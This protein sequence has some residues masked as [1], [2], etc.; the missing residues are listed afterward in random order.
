MLSLLSS[1]VS[2]TN[3]EHNSWF[4]TNNVYYAHQL[5]SLN[6]QLYQKRNANFLSH[7][8]EVDLI[9]QKKMVQRFVHFLV[10]HF[11]M[12]R[13]WLNLY[14]ASNTIT[15]LIHI[16][17]N[18]NLWKYIYRTTGPVKPVSGIDDFFSIEH[19]T[20]VFVVH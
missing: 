5:Y 13:V 6:Q 4:S 20:V 3:T 9:K 14:G 15:A 18:L 11:F 8:P 19:Y 7:S 10:T 1:P 17:G 12:W 2:K 16:D